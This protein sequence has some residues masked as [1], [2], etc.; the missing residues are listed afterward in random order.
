MT[1]SIFGALGAS[2]VLL[3]GLLFR[4]GMVKNKNHKKLL[5]SMS[6]CDFCSSITGSCEVM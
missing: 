2:A 4:N 3:T 6:F 5:M 1:G